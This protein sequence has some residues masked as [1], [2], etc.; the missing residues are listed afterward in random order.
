MDSV[1]RAKSITE[2]IIQQTSIDRDR[3]RLEQTISITKTC[4]T[5]SGLVNRSATARQ[6]VIIFD[7][8]PETNEP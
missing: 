4:Y 7:E 8:N 3:S 6:G 1:G 2:T 5:L